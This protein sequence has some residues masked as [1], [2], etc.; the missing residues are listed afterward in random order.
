M[1][2]ACVVE[3]MMRKLTPD[4][5]ILNDAKRRCVALVTATPNGLE[6]A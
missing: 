1:H 6:L 5:V 4:G 3:I 2:E